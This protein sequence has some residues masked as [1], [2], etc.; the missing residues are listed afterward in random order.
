MAHVNSSTTKISTKLSRSEWSGGSGS[1]CAMIQPTTHY[2]LLTRKRLSYTLMIAAVLVAV[3]LGAVLA[4]SV[5]FILGVLVSPDPPF[6]SYL[7]KLP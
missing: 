6:W 7:R 1:H 2:T 5:L 4:G 3:I